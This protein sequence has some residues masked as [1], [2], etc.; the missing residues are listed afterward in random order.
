MGYLVDIVGKTVKSIKVVEAQDGKF[1]R[2]TL[3]FYESST[4]FVELDVEA[5]CES[6]RAY[7]DVEVR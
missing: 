2:L 1:S 6:E 7:L 5:N 4:E 3:T